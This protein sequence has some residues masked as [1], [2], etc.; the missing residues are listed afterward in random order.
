MGK[1]L[2]AREEFG[3]F[4]RRRKVLTRL[5]D[6]PYPDRETILLIKK[7]NIFLGI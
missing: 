3:S 1:E 4:A 7:E 6:S 5:I 2:P